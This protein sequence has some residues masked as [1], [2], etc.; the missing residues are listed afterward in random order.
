M[1]KNSPE[2]SGAAGGCVW[3]ESIHQSTSSSRAPAAACARM[4]LSSDVVTH[5]EDMDGVGHDQCVV[6][7]G[8]RVFEKIALYHVDPR[9]LGLAGEA[10]PRDGTGSRQFEQ[11]RLQR[12]IAPQHGDQERTRPTADIEH[13]VVAGEI[14]ADCECC[15]HSCC[16]CLNPG[17]EDLL[18][19][20]SEAIKMPLSFATSHSVFE[21][22]PRRIADAVQ[23][24]Q[25]R[26]QVLA[27]FAAEKGSRRGA[28][29]V[30][31]LLAL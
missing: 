27:S 1:T 25:H 4:F 10:V 16:G 18:L 30:A 17:R 23:K 28:V 21:L 2:N 3:V 8:Q 31:T 13:P 12:G 20:R 24:T 22:H 6:I 26:P 29:A 11:C 5:R 14:V 7:V 9:P 15:R 19:L